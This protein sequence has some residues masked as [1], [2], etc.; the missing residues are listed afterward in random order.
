[1]IRLLLLLLLLLLLVVNVRG[2]CLRLPCQYPSSCGHCHHH[3]CWQVMLRLLHHQ[4]C[5]LPAFAISSCH[6]CHL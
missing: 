6:I 5:A 4:A 1:M 3:S 2:A